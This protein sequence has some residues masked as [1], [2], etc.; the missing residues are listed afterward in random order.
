MAV[1]IVRAGQ[2]GA[3]RRLGLRAPPSVILSHRRPNEKARIA[4]K[5][6]EFAAIY[7]ENCK[8]SCTEFVRNAK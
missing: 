1:G 4:G 8:K 3:S 2:G 5:C 6:P 7:G